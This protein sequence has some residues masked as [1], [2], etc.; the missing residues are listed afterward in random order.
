MIRL[1]LLPPAQKQT[2][3]RVKT[4]TLVQ[5]LLIIFFVFI[6]LSSSAAFYARLTLERKFAQTI[7]ESAPGS[8][9]IAE[10]NRDI[11]QTNLRLRALQTSYKET[12]LWS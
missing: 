3:G 2:L 5:E 8:R 12:L 11:E 4:L 7:L 9:K 10:L 1:N 6:L